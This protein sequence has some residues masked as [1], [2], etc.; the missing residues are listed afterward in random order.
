MYN[1]YSEDYIG[2][3]GGLDP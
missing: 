3:R 1:L 2:G